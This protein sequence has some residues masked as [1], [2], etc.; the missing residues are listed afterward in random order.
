MAE[1]KDIRQRELE[2]ELF[3]TDDPDYGIIIDT[4]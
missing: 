2:A 4:I 3:P 1:K